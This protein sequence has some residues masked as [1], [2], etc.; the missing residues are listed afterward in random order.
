M[1][2][3]TLL[4]LAVASTLTLTGCLD[5]GDN[6]RN[7]APEYNITNPLT[8]GIT[9]AVFNP[10]TKEFPI[11]NDLTF[12]QGDDADGTMVA[13][14]RLS[15]LDYLDGNSTSAPFDIKFSAPLDPESVDSR[16]FVPSPEPTQGGILVPNPAQNVFLLDLTY[17]GGDELKSIPGEIP[18]FQAGILYQGYVA[19]FTAWA[20]AGAPTSGAVFDAK[21]S[22]EEALLKNVDFRAEVVQQDGTESYL[23]I[24]PQT[25]LNPESKYLVVVT[26]EVQD[27][28]ANP[29]GQ[30]STYAN[31]SDPNS[32]LG[33]SSLEPVRTAILGWERLAAG[34]FGAATNIS[35]NALGVDS[36]SA[37]NISLSLTFTTG[38]TDTVL[39]SMAAPEIFFIKKATIE[40]RQEGITELVSD[41]LTLTA[42]EFPNIPPENTTLNTYF[43]GA[44]TTPGAATYIEELDPT[45]PNGNYD[46][47]LKYFS[48]LTDAT[49]LFK[50]QA[51]AAE[52]SISIARGDSAPFNGDGTDLIV[53]ASTTTAGLISGGALQKPTSGITDKNGDTFVTIQDTF[54]PL[55]AAAQGTPPTGAVSEYALPS[56]SALGLPAEGF[57]LQ[58]QIEVPYFLPDAASEANK[59]GLLTGTWTAQPGLGA[60][61]DK[62]TYRFPFAEKVAMENIPFLLS[63]P[64]DST[65]PASGNGWPVVIY[66][67]GIFGSRGHSLPIGNTLGA[68]CLTANPTNA[69]VQ[70]PA[71]Q[72]AP[73]C[74]VTIAIDQPLHGLAPTVA[75][76]DLDSLAAAGLSVDVTSAAD[77][78]AARDWSA[79][80]YAGL[81]E[82]HFGWSKTSS[83]DSTPTEMAYSADAASAHG[84]S[85]EY[86]INL[87]LPPG[88]RD[89]LR[90][91]AMDLLTLTASL[92][93][94]DLDGNPA[95]QD[96]DTDRVFFVGHSLGGIVGTTYSATNNDPSVQAFNMLPAL[97]AVA[98][99]T[100]GGQITR[101]LENSA[102]LGSTIL[103]GLALNEVSQGSSTFEIFMNTTQ[104]AIDSG[105]SINFA[106][107]LANTGTPIL[108]TEVYGDGSDRGTQDQTIPVNT[109][110]VDGAYLA[111]SGIALNTPLGG[112]EPL[113]RELDLDNI[114]S[115]GLA[116]DAAG[117]Q[118]AVRFNQ[119]SHT[120]I[121]TADN[122][123]VFTEM[124]TQLV[125]FFSSQGLE[126]AV[127]AAT[128][129]DGNPTAAVISDAEPDISK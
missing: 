102:S 66:Q 9:Y 60:P 109:D 111:Q 40:A 19:A 73:R 45:D 53:A 25:P 64:I 28:Q 1:Y 55:L 87:A 57:V 81:H 37:D 125:T 86:Y 71:G 101:I 31:L 13:N 74:F 8:D 95:T 36:L 90:Q 23:R 4:S 103:E 39:K 30:S 22:A 27:S 44:I 16:A 26:N 46:P 49:M 69:E 33:S 96:L 59:N 41:K 47:A 108:A 122:L 32:P 3:K 120:T 124:A 10:V 92:K 82:R 62:I 43:L 97:K 129:S 88:S 72:D 51:G 70:N 56:Q 75:T 35:R 98:L 5:D 78:F 116:T 54:L 52:A 76:G 7:A 18:T 77:G 65:R 106:A 34:W 6:F 67:H 91:S 68:G 79:T 112:T 80:P 107:A 2:K 104:A 20:N 100:T 14:D 127:G 94:I 113:L 21:E 99:E 89:N 110:S 128:D 105:D 123:T 85:G 15:G 119:G 84:F 58:G 11:P 38:G 61:S 48:D 126:V 63:K 50:A 93:D 24:S 29:V 118:S 42:S 12:E 83:L 117:I 17:A 121:I 114:T 115:P